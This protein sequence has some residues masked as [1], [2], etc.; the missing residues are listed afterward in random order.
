MDWIIFSLIG[1]GAGW[2][3]GYVM[4]RDD[5]G[6]ISDLMVGV[7]S[8]WLGGFLLR[9]LCVSGGGLLCSLIVVILIVVPFGTLALLFGLRLF[10]KG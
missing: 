2:I 5:R 6:V 1:V 4:K 3:A 7:S 8:A 9:E 10:Q